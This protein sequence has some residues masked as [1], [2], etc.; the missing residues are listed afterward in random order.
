[1]KTVRLGV[2]HFKSK[3]VLQD[4]LTLGGNTLNVEC[5]VTKGGDLSESASRRPNRTV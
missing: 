2:K 4:C 3:N 1:M 5:Q